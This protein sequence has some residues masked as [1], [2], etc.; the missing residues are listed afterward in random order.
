MHGDVQLNHHCPWMT[1]FGNVASPHNVTHASL[2]K[3]NSLNSVAHFKV[4][5]VISFSFK[6]KIQN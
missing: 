1:L 6:K 5:L 2:D 3:K 4:A